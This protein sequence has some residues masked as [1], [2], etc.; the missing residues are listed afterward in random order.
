MGWG[1]GIRPS[2]HGCS[3]SR[4]LFIYILLTEER[5][6]VGCGSYSEVDENSTS[7]ESLFM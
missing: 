6:R 2:G 1:G 4:Q 7:Q 3:Q 5:E